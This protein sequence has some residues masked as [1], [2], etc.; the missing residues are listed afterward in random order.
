VVIA[1]QVRGWNKAL[2][3]RLPY[4]REKAKT[5]LAEAGYPEGFEVTGLPEQ[6]LS[7]MNPFARQSLRCWRRSAFRQAQCD[8]PRCLFSEDSKYDT[9]FICSDGN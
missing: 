7:T 6:S 5:L 8:A 3:A 2:D 9:S 1:P 4:D